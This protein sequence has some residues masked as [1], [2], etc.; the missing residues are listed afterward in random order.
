MERRADEERKNGEVG[1]AGGVGG[2]SALVTVVAERGQILVIDKEKNRR[3]RSWIGNY[4]SKIDKNIRL[5][6]KK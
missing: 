6:G 1:L 2:G 3:R 4:K 5:T